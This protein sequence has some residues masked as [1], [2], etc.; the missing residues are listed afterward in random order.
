MI[1]CLFSAFVVYC[2]DEVRECIRISL[3]FLT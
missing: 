3:V 1:P 2:A